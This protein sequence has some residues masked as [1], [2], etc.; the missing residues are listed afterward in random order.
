MVRMDRMLVEKSVQRLSA[1]IEG[2]G[3]S[4]VNFFGESTS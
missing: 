4:R 2:I 1:T 3:M